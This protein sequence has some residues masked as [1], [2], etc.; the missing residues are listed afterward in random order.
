M[1]VNSWGFCD[2]SRRGGFCLSLSV[3]G[4]VK[5]LGMV[6]HWEGQI[7]WREKRKTNAGLGGSAKSGVNA[8][9]AESLAFLQSNQLINST[10]KHYSGWLTANYR[11]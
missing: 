7:E 1:T 10:E 11:E 4:K 2:L 3:S 6:K 9:A 5:H 8:A